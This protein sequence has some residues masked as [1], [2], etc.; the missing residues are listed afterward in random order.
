MP[1]AWCATATSSSCRPGSVN[2]RACWEGLWRRRTDV[3]KAAGEVRGP[4][5]S[6]YTPGGCGAGIQ[7]DALASA[8]P[9]AVEQ[10]PL[11]QVCHVAFVGGL[12][13]GTLRRYP[14]LERKK[15][16]EAFASKSLISLLVFGRDGGIRTRY[17]LHPMG[18][19]AKS[20]GIQWDAMRL[21]TSLQINE[22]RLIFG[23]GASSKIH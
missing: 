12:L 23:P 5:P 1:C 3:N 22:L 20:R 8:A 13:D 21:K 17:P 9:A 18:L 2:D 14:G 7:V 6:I 16:L 4:D 19:E 10:T 11:R 15:D